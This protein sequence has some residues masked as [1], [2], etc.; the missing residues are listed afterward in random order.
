MLPT[1]CMVGE[2]SPPGRGQPVARDGV[3]VLGHLDADEPAARLGAGDAAAARAHE[4]VEHRASLGRYGH[5]VP[6]EGDGLLG[7][8]QARFRLG[9]G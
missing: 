2:V 6:Q 3:V 8:M 7:Y 9:G 1:R 4:G 5:E